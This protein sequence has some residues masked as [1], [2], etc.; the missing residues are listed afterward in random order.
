MSLTKVKHSMISGGCVNVLDYGAVGNGIADDTAAIQAATNAAAGKAVYFP[1]GYEFYINQGRIDWTSSNT[2]WI[3]DGWGSKIRWNPA[4]DTPVDNWGM[5]N[6]HGTNTA[7]ISKVS[8]R[9]LYFDFGRNKSSTYNGF[10]RGVHIFNC[11]DIEITGCYF[12]GA[13]GEM[14]GINNRGTGGCQR[15]LV[16]QNIFEDYPQNGLNP[17]GLYQTI[18]GNIFRN[19]GSSS[20]IEI[21]GQYWTFTGNVIHDHVFGLDLSNPTDFLVDGNSFFNVKTGIQFSN[22]SVGVASYRG[23]ISNNTFKTASAVSGEYGILVT[24]GAGGVDNT[25][26]DVI[27]NTVTGYYT[28]IRV[29]SNIYGN[30]CD[31][32]VDG[33]TYGNAGFEIG[34]SG[35]SV[36]SVNLNNNT[37]VRNTTDYNI[38]ALSSGEVVVGVNVATNGQFT[39][40]NTIGSTANQVTLTGS[41]AE[42]D[43]KEIIVG[44]GTLPVGQGVTVKA[45]GETT[46]TAGNKTIRLYFYNQLVAT[47]P[48]FATASAFQI[49]ATMWSV[50]SSAQSWNVKAYVGT[51]LV[52]NLV[53]ATTVSTTSDREILVTGELANTG[54]SVLLYGMTVLKF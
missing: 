53:G 16:S 19:G 8:I 10:E 54:D 43:L 2:S 31:N 21:G 37:S 23:V 15:V 41:T 32:I 3:G 24:R 20:K 25:E 46:G 14:V 6:I 18:A 11:N 48:A 47:I 39:A 34:S 35:G 1:S 44:G 13:A 30:I 38:A 26:I 51:S 33:G 40:A 42:T 28:G 7:V 52:L 45:V 50:S 22:Q 4:T 36:L 49:E 9:N 5:L 29:T 27:G 17:N 12:K